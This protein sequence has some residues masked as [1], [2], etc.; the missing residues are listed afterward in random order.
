MGRLSSSLTTRIEGTFV[1]EVGVV[2]SDDISG[3]TVNHTEVG[4]E[5]VV[6]G[7]RWG[8]DEG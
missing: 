5:P 8:P 2:R 7:N 4:V 3:E 1:E 6:P